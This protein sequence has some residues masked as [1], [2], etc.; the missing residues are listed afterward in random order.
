MATTLSTKEWRKK[1]VLK[2]LCFTI[3]FSPFPS[4]LR[5]PSV[6]SKSVMALETLSP[7]AASYSACQ[8]RSIEVDVVVQVC[9]GACSKENPRCKATLNLSSLKVGSEGDCISIQIGWL[10][11]HECL[12][13]GNDWKWLIMETLCFIY[14]RWRQ[15][16]LRS[17]RLPSM[18]YKYY[19]IHHLPS[20]SSNKNLGKRDDSS[21]LFLG[22][23]SLLVARKA[24]K[25]RSLI[26][27]TFQQKF[28]CLSLFPSRWR[29]LHQNAYRIYY[30]HVP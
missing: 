1:Q 5:A 26:G 12:Q 10:H 21:N 30:S 17:C 23:C 27:P 24:A 16:R 20:S 2:E 9:T 8:F 28:S 6:A 7:V 11:M 13:C 19:S 3:P 25:V 29:Q 18:I 15:S 4:I 14:W 22:V